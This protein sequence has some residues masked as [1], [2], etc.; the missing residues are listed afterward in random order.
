MCSSACPACLLHCSMLFSC[1]ANSFFIDMHS[2]HHQRLIAMPQATVDSTA[3]RSCNGMLEHFG[4]E[5]LDPWSRIV[6]KMKYSRRTFCRPSLSPMRFFCAVCLSYRR[7]SEIEVKKCQGLAALFLWSSP[8]DMQ[9]CSESL[10]R[11]L[12]PCADP[13]VPASTPQALHHI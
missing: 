2:I 9:R 13:P 11:V 3:L 5:P 7:C 8:S 12:L 10:F 4:E 1:S 6:S